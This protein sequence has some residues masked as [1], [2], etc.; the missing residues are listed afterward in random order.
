MSVL[1]QRLTG[2]RGPRHPAELLVPSRVEYEASGT[3]SL[4]STPA[5]TAWRPP[6]RVDPAGLQ[7]NLGDFRRKALMEAPVWREY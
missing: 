1:T 7:E 5:V 2:K 6:F 3:R 4:A